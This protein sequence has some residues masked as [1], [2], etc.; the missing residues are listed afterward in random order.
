MT[1]FPHTFVFLL[2]AL[3]FW[4]KASAEQSFVTL[5]CP[6]GW[7]ANGQSW[8]VPMDKSQNWTHQTV[9]ITASFPSL[10]DLKNMY[11]QFVMCLV[12]E[13][14]V[15][16][17]HCNIKGKK[18]WIEICIHESGNFLN[19]S[20][21]YQSEKNDPN[22]LVLKWNT[23][24]AVCG[25]EIQDE[26][27]MLESVID[28]SKPVLCSKVFKIRMDDK[29][30][31]SNDPFSEI[32]LRCPEASYL[33]GFQTG[34]ILCHQSNDVVETFCI[35]CYSTRKLLSVCINDC[36][37]MQT[38]MEFSHLVNFSYQHNE[39]LKGGKY[40]GIQR[41]LNESVPKRFD[42]KW[43][44]SQEHLIVCDASTIDSMSTAFIAVIVISL[45]LNITLIIVV[46]VIT[47][48]KVARQ[49]RERPRE[50]EIVHIP[51]DDARVTT[52]QE[53]DNETP[54]NEFYRNPY[55]AQ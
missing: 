10:Y 31:A 27:T 38:K 25:I 16:F 23:T 13:Y 19:Q 11:N 44:D 15:P 45:I 2:Q 34:A 42:H 9:V 54:R 35:V 32:D 55:Y 7:K 4:L 22:S 8:Y 50:L 36:E 28:T 20:M 51:V 29:T 18:K 46:V 53:P 37:L 52:N 17:F 30:L 48:Q 26:S 41:K 6:F 49:L 47:R 40:C 3:V 33:N 43:I 1:F 12:C 5:E 14:D 39:K 24:S 21:R